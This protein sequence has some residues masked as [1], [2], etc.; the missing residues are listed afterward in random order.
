MRDDDG[1][2]HAEVDP[3]DDSSAQ[4]RSLAGQCKL[5]QLML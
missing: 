1:K 3:E 4:V 2:A 5:H